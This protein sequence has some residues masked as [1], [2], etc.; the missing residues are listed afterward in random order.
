MAR[1][2]TSGGDLQDHQTTD[3]GSPDGISGGATAT[4]TEATVVRSGGFSF[5]CAGTSGNT[6]FRWWPF[7][8]ALAT[9]Y[10]ARAC[11][12]FAAFPNATKK[13]LAF[14]T[15]AD[16]ALVSA[17]LTSGGNLQLWD[18][19][20]AAQIGSDSTLALALDTWY[21]IE[22]YLK[23]GAGAVDAAELRLLDP[24]DL[25]WNA[26]TTVASG[27]SLTISD[28]APGKLSSGWVDAPGVT[29][30]VFLDDVALNDSTGSAQNAWPGPGRIIY[31]AGSFGTYQQGWVSCMND[32]NKAAV[33]IRP[34]AGHADS[35]SDTAR[36][37]I[38]SGSSS[39]TPATKMDTHTLG[40]AGM[41]GNCLPVKQAF[42]AD[43]SFGASSVLQKYGGSFYCCGTVDYVTANLKKVGT[44][45]DNVVLELRTDDGAGKPSSTVLASQSY[46]GSALLTTYTTV[47]MDLAALP[48]ALNTRYWL[49]YGRSGAVDAANFYKIPAAGGTK[50]AERTT[51]FWNGTIWNSPFTNATYSFGI[52]TLQGHHRVRVAVPH[53]CHAEA[54]TLGTKTGTL[55]L[56]NTADVALGSEASFNFGNDLGI[57]GDYPSAWRWVI[58]GPAYDVAIDSAGDP[59]RINFTK[60]DG[61]TRVAMLA[62]IGAYAEW[63]EPEPVWVQYQKTSDSTLW[64]AEQVSVQTTMAYGEPET[65]V[66]AETGDWFITPDPLPA[67]EAGFTSLATTT[68]EDLLANYTLV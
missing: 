46:D 12:R 36:H 16:G 20:G 56:Y 5:K 58:A 65:N 31:L 59:L 61:T 30:D 3:L 68:T 50:N 62:C 51:T 66:V 26:G 6:S 28:T 37:Q 64:W 13:V 2:V 8:G 19:V 34:P 47:R 23:I 67:E 48:L 10:Y 11:L 24:D 55:R 54:I 7:T 57:A 18:D 22:L 53:A 21:R 49:V 1:L 15:A 27:A 4:A 9:G 39:T 14:T 52:Y 17:R 41:P 45:T 43:S 33:D 63:M 44:P 60:T 35:T 42:G 38:R 25:E 29:A 32:A 40:W